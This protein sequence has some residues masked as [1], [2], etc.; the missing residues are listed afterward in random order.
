MKVSIIIPIY[1]VASYIE[2]CLQS[3]FHQTYG[4]IEVIIVDDCGTDNSMRIVE[5]ITSTYNGNFS[6][7]ILH[8]D[9]NKGLSAA[10]NTGIKE[11]TGE[12]IFFL[13]S[14]DTIP[15]DAINNLVQKVLT[16]TNVS[17]VIGGI[18]TTG[19][20]RKRYP[21]L[22]PEF[23]KEKF[24]LIDFLNHKWNEMAC[25]KLINKAFLI[26][27]QLWFMENVYH[28]DIDFTFR[29]AICAKTMACCYNVTYNYLIRDKSITTC[30]NLKNY[31]DECN[32]HK[33]NL[34]TL[35]RLDYKLHQTIISKYAINIC[36]N[37]IVSL[38]TEKNSKITTQEKKELIHHLLQISQ[39]I[40]SIKDL[41]FPYLIKNAF[42]HLPFPLQYCVANIYA[43]LK[44]RI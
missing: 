13:D 17:F 20:Q 9:Q 22:C 7:K 26:Q 24:I 39:E 25:N 40:I 28:E 35:I 34:S 8:H 1:N 15:K 11:S 44:K 3:V 33:Q 19:Y 14:D 42:I 10:R 29:L 32:I 31:I 4:D 2:A 36:F 37:Y 41:S 16:H 12:Y 5:K 6:I 43:D 27:N 21:L 23:Q 18:Q 38:I 30:K